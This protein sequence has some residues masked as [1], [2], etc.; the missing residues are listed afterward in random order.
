MILGHQRHLYSCIYMTTVDR[1]FTVDTPYIT[2]FVKTSGSKYMCSRRF[3]YELLCMCA[4]ED[5][6]YMCSRRFYKLYKF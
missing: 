1:S 5:I 2:R 4:Q 3:Y 6:M